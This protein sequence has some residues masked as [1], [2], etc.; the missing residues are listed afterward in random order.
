MI[1]VTPP[2]RCCSCSSPKSRPVYPSADP[3]LWEENAVEL[4]LKPGKTY[5]T[6]VCRLRYDRRTAQKHVR[7]RTDG[8]RAGEERARIERAS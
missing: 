5:T 4:E 3:G 1:I 6:A 7:A 2:S 8:I